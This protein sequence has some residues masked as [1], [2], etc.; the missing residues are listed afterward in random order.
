VPVFPPA[1]PVTVLVDGRPI[2][3]YVRA[4]VRD[5]RVFMPVATVLHNLADRAW[6]E[7]GAVVAA[8]NG[9]EARIP[10][11]RTGPGAL[12]TT[13]VSVAPLARALGDSVAYDAIAHRLEIR[14]APGLPVASPTPFGASAVP[15][16][17]STV[18]TPVPPAT[19]RPIWSGPALPRR[20]PL[21][22]P[23]P[24]DAIGSQ[25]ANSSRDERTR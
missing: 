17:A 13:F 24:R 5:G 8:R 10:I 2:A 25:P 19:P 18:F 23:P 21:P 12:E 22:N 14:T 16:P 20:T 7:G 9:R 6:F 3:A 4:F 11:G 1:A 15:I